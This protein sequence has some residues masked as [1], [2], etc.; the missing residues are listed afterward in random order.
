MGLNLFGAVPF[1]FLNFLFFY[2][3]CPSFGHPFGTW[4]SCRLLFIL[5]A[6]LSWI[7]VNFLNQNP[8][9]PS[10]PGICQFD[11]FFSVLF[12][13]SVFLISVLLWVLLFCHVAYPYFLVCSLGCNILFQNYSAFLASSCWYVFMWSLLT[14]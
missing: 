9:I 11:I 3:C 10:W 5:S 6:S 14:Y 13:K 1:H 12:S 4:A 8:C 2:H 7:V